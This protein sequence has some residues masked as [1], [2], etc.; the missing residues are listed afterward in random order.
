MSRGLRLPTQLGD[1]EREAVLV[2]RQRV[3][4]LFGLRIR[5]ALVEQRLL[6][7]EDELLVA[8]RAHGQPGEHQA[9]HE[10]RQHEHQRDLLHGMIMRPIWLGSHPKLSG[11]GKRLVKELSR[12]P[13]AL[14]PERRKPKER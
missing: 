8:Q 5:H 3:L 10:H 13:A 12:E 2:F 7:F 4:H 6:P 11:A 1:L 9:G 14:K